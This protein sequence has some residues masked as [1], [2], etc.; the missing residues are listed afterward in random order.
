VATPQSGDRTIDLALDL[1]V[2]AL[3]NEIE[4]ERTLVTRSAAPT[5]SIREEQYSLSAGM[6]SDGKQGAPRIKAQGG[7][8][9]TE[10]EET[11]VVYGMPVLRPS[12]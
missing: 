7:R 4:N 12:A 11:S 2:F 8:I 1:G 10:A 3:D 5:N 6:G 9:Y